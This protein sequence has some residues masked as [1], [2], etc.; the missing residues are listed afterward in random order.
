VWLINTE[1][2]AERTALDIRTDRAAAVVCWVEN[3][4]EAFRM[5]IGVKDSLFHQ[6]MSCALSAVSR[7][8]GCSELLTPGGQRHC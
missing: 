6:G 3:G 5:Y 1:G 2:V 4:T 8:A 7:P